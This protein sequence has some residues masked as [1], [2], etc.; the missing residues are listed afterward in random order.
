MYQLLK[1]G[2][3]I[4]A[5]GIIALGVLQFFT[6]E[7]ILGRPPALTWPS[8]AANMSGKLVSAYISGSILIL[9]GLAIIFLKVGRL[10]AMLIAVIAILYSFFMRHLPAMADWVNT[11]KTLAI[12]GGAFITA[13][14]FNEQKNERSIS[15][16]D[17]D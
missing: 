8:W 1:P 15:L 16:T 13:A 10:A 14:S 12:A 3:V 17:H 7:Y 6:R 4:F 11:F 9:S 5:L 2:R